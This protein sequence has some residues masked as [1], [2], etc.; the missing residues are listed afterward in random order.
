MKVKPL[1]PRIRKDIFGYFEDYSEKPTHDPG[2][3][4]ICPFCA[5]KL[6]DERKTLSLALFDPEHRDRSYFYR[7]CR[8]C[9][10]KASDE[11]KDQMDYSLIDILIEPI[12]NKS[13]N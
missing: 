5:N 3:D 10:N 7:T 2:V 13:N 11:E 6:A 1:D 9:Y 4:T 12:L 8:A